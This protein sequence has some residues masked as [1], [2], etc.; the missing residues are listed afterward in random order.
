[1]HAKHVEQP[2]RHECG[3]PLDQTIAALDER[4]RGVVALEGFEH[5]RLFPQA[6]EGTH[7]VKPAAV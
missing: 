6:L 7:D 4:R 2:T 5:R 1:M 3:R